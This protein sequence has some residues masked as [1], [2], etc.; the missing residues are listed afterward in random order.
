VQCTRGDEHWYEF[1][2]EGPLTTFF[3]GMEP[4]SDAMASPRRSS[5]LEL[6]LG[7]G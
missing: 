5:A 6:P 3:G 2:G 4:L 1:D 7:V